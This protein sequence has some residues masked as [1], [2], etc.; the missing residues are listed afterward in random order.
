[1]HVLFYAVG[2]K[3]HG[4]MD[5]EILAIGPVELVAFP[6]LNIPSAPHEA[7][8]TIA[9]IYGTCVPNIQIS[10]FNG[11]SMHCPFDLILCITLEGHLL[12]LIWD[13][14]SHMSIDLA[15]TNLEI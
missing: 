2:A 7:F 13:G 4:E 9:R 14:T 3:V 8:A 10:L 15:L 5:A 11:N 12:K 6:G 1:M